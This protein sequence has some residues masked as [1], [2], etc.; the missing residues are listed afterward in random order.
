MTRPT[1]IISAAAVEPAV[2]EVPGVEA[3]EFLRFPEI[4]AEPGGSQ[5]L[6]TIS[7][8]QAARVFDFDWQGDASDALFAQLGTDGAL[9]ETNLAKS[10]GLRTGDTFTVTSNRGNKGSFTVLGEYRDPVLFTGIT[11]S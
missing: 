5:F 8:A 11:V 6:N 3:T 4:R 1:P 7:P 9:I 10:S 2:R